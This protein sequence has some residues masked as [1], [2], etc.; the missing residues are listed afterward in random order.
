MVHVMACSLFGTNSHRSITF[1][2]ELLP[3]E[4]SKT[5]YN[6]CIQS[7]GRCQM[8][9]LLCTQ[10][11]C[12]GVQCKHSLLPDSANNEWNSFCLHAVKRDQPASGSL[13]FSLDPGQCQSS[14]SASLSTA[15]RRG[16]WKAS[17]ISL[18]S[19]MYPCMEAFKS[20]HRQ[21]T[22]TL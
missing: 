15:G 9:L 19:V 3:I 18:S 5:N 7:F 21:K 1:N 22:A 16:H 12:V 13:F 11:C 10:Y 4:P 20:L 2:A 14:L 8:V 17:C 6:V